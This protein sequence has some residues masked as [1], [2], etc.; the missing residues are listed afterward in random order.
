VEGPFAREKVG[1]ERDDGDDG[2]EELSFAQKSSTSIQKHPM[3]T[4]LCMF[5]PPFREGG[6]AGQ[7]G[8]WGWLEEDGRGIE[9]SRR[10]ANR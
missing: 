5:S 9:A 1:G 8:A 2:P 3:N 7:L 6:R 10:W 4:W